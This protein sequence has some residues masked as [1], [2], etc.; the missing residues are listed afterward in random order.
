MKVLYSSTRY[1]GALYY[2]AAEPARAV[3]EGGFGV[4]VTLTYGLATTMDGPVEDE[5]SSVVSVDAQGADVVVLQLPKTKAALEMLRLLQAQ[6]VAVVVELDDLMSGLAYGHASYATIQRYNV[7]SWAATCAR[8]A[9]LVTVTTPALLGEYAKHGRGVVVPNAIPRRIAELPPAYERDPETV[10]VGWSG[11]VGGHPYDLQ[12]ME[13]GLQQGLDR[14]RRAGRFMIL[15]QAMDAQ[16]R[17][18]LP[19]PPL[20]VPWK[21]TVDEYLTAMGELF[22]VGIAPLRLDRFNESKSWLKPLEYSA[23]GVFAIRAGTADYERLGLGLRAK[24]P[25]DWADHICKAIDDPD[26]RREIAARNREVV[27]A[28][29]LDE[30]TAPLWADAWHRALDNRV[31]SQRIG[32]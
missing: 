1:P 7:A 21:Q 11:S 5:S 4:E 24:R 30:H 29:H 17:L 18:H 19:E 31:R 23:R 14:A 26:R 25:R 2:R 22:D 6:G 3:N 10:T 9:D 8:E 32:A 28:N 15:G 27:L 16:Q 13:S 20:E 12:T